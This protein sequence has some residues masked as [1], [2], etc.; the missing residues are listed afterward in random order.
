M[1]STVNKNADVIA[2]TAIAM[3]IESGYEKVTISEICKAAGVSRS[4]FYATFS[5]KSQI[6]EYV[7]ERSIQDQEVAFS[8]ILDA[9]N[10]FERM[11]V[12]CD[13]H[14]SHTL[15][16][17]PKLGV[18]LLQL[19]VARK[20]DILEKTQDLFDWLIRLGNNAKA[21]GLINTP[22]PL[23]IM[24]PL[25]INSAYQSA[26]EWCRCGGTFNLR[27]RARVILESAL[28]AAPEHRWTKKQLEKA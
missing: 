24:V 16:F 21:A 20:I 5:G 8:E 13:R 23:E 15:R 22:E 11:W 3:F 26:Y 28:N 27:A 2:N 12:L 7:L 6:I 18:T 10:D 17:G 19:D 1:S 4:V 9:P 14:L 25:F